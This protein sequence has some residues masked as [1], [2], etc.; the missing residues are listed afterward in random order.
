MGF[1]IWGLRF[2]ALGS[3]CQR[4]GSGIRDPGSGIWVP[5]SGIRDSGSGFRV[6]G[7][8]IRVPGFGSLD[9]GSGIRVSGSRFPVPDFGVRVYLAGGDAS[10][11]VTSP[12]AST[13]P[14]PPLEPFLASSLEPFPAPGVSSSKVDASKSSKVDGLYAESSAAST[15]NDSSVDACEV[16]ESFEVVEEEGE[17]CRLEG[18]TSSWVRV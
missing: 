18:G 6:S 4:S 8:G 15:S 9:L 1:G 16:D 5:G 10:E 11:Q 7:S 3:G 13:G 14:P 12:S 17:D 2:R